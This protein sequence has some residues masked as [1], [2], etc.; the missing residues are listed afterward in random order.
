MVKLLPSTFKLPPIHKLPPILAPPITW[1]APLPDAVACVVFVTVVIPLDVNVVNAPVDAVMLPI[2]VELIAVA[3]VS[4][5][6]VL[7]LMFS[8]PPFK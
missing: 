3:W 1:N 6:N 8:V 7:P 4:P 2:G 5:S